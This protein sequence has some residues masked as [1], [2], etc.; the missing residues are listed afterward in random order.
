MTLFPFYV[1]LC[2]HLKITGLWKKKSLELGMRQGTRGHFVLLISAACI[3]KSSIMLL[4]A[5]Q[6][7]PITQAP[8]CS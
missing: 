8:T 6:T 7:N 1:T 2:N 5:Q 4:N 3:Y